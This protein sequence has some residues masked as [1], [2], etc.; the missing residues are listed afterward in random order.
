MMRYYITDRRSAGGA[1]ALI[2]IVQ[3]A[4]EQGVERVQIREKDLSARELVQAFR[5][6]GF[7]QTHRSRESELPVA[8]FPWRTY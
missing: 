1:G 4:L 7:E 6:D 8:H 3:R 5:P 2:G